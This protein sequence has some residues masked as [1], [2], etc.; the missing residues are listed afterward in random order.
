MESFGSRVIMLRSLICLSFTAAVSLA[1]AT[2]GDDAKPKAAQSQSK[3]DEK[4]TV[5][6]SS[7]AIEDFRADA[8][9]YD[10]RLASRPKEKLALRDEPLLHWGN[11]ARTGEDGAVFAWM[12]DG[13]PEVIASVFT[14]RLTNVIRRKHEYHSLAAGPLTANYQGKRVWAPTTAGVT[15]QQL[16]GAPEPADT[17]RQR[18]SQMKGLAREFSA[19]ILEKDGQQADLRLV[20]QPLIRYEPK[21][22]AAIDGAIFS[23]A[24]GTDPE[25]L[26]LIEARTEKGQT[27]WQ[28]ACARYHYVD[29]R[30]FHK[31]K[32]V[33]HA[34]AFPDEISSLDIGSPKFQDSV[35][36]TYHTITT[37]IEE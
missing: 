24:L 28:F 30:T 2:T 5:A 13:R 31:D 14:Y 20:A 26:L 23:F 18:L 29:L 35:Y 33:W 15:F 7:K 19:R 1:S 10:I 17:P 21:N 25:V 3:R 16:P 36:T 4:T 34:A 11:P 27:A 6:E 32:E 12:L 22:Q 9:Q 8:R 37:P